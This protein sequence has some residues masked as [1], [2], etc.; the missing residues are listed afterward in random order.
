MDARAPTPG[1]LP[2]EREGRILRGYGFA[3]RAARRVAGL[4]A[5]ALVVAPL[6]VPAPASG[7]VDPYLCPGGGITKIGYWYRI[8]A[9][10]FPVGPSAVTAYS[11]GKL[12]L[13]NL[14][15]TNGH[16][17][18][19][20]EAG[21]CGWREAYRL[22]DPG[23]ASYHRNNSFIA[24]LEVSPAGDLA[25]AVI[26]RDDALQKP[27]MVMSRDGGRT[28][29]AA[30][31]GALAAT[32]GRF[33][34]LTFVASDPRNAYMLVDVEYEASVLGLAGAKVE[35]VQLVFRS[36]NSGA[37]WQIAG[38][39]S[40]RTRIEIEGSSFEMNG[41]AGEVTALEADP[42]TTTDVWA[43]G[44]AGLFHSSDGG[45][46]YAEAGLG[47][48]GTV[49][50]VHV[51][52][53]AARVL[54]TAADDATYF[55]SGDGGLSFASGSLP[56]VVQSSDHLFGDDLA[57]ATYGRVYT[58]LN[59]PGAP[60][61]FFDVSPIDGRVIQDVSVNG[62][63]G[64]A[65]VGRTTT[66][67]DFLPNP[68][69]VPVPEEPDPTV[70]DDGDVRTYSGPLL[71]PQ[72][73]RVVLDPGE[74]RRIDYVLDQPP[75]PTPLDV[76][77]LI[78]VS[79]SMSGTIDGVRSA[80]NDIVNRLRDTG[81]DVNFGVARYRAYDD[82]PAY[83]RTLDIG[84]PGE[85]LADALD[86]L[87]AQGGGE[88][89]QL[90]ALYQSATG[91]GQNDPR[92]AIPSGGQFHFREG[93]LRVA[94]HA[95]D[96]VFSEGYPHPSYETVIGALRDVGIRQVG[97]AIQDITPAGI[98]QGFVGEP[99]HGLDRVAEGTQAVAPLA[100]A[101][102]DGDG[103]SD[104]AYGEPLVCAIPPERADEAGVMAEAIV[105]VLTSIQRPETV[106]FQ[107]VPRVTDLS[108]AAASKVVR[109]VTPG[110]IPNVDLTKPQRLS[111]QVKVGCPRLR[112]SD[113]FPVQVAAISSGQT[114][115]TAELTVVCRVP[116]L[117]EEE[118]PPP[119]LPFL[120]V[121]AIPPPPPRPPEPVPEPN[122]NPQP[123]PQGNPQPQ[124]GLAQQEQEQPQ[125]ALAH[126]GPA[127]E[128]EAPAASSRGGER[129]QM[130]KYQQGSEQR[131]PP[132]TILTL[133]AMTLT[134]AFG[135]AYLLRERTR[136][137]EARVGRHRPHY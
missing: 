88:E 80:M 22:P 95:T 96:E 26:Q 125:L 92:A 54:A 76:Y 27:H 28:W 128:A 81:I 100:G 137:Q 47:P 52:T 109:E 58:G 23:G 103:T 43:F 44:Q 108:A 119:P 104:I 114:L 18:M 94:I 13:D 39:F 42:S 126:Q 45:S 8:D 120:Q 78:D 48:V 84:P 122:P 77:F 10:S 112:A 98:E 46:T 16:A 136:T 60:P 121:V 5:T 69:S 132:E 57:I 134:M 51:P 50:I 24:A 32:E 15:V 113:T 101:D 72:E 102:C 90:A 29:S 123:N 115:G 133:G 55:R 63:S 36:T 12:N 67:V 107:A 105:N 117:E 31:G 7:Q 20:A 14:Y 9:P 3:V 131:V 135:S 21:G 118:L 127:V 87:Y 41:A 64:G 106:S 4:V 61:T 74:T 75:S 111:F 97:L 86:D 65:I 35:T 89:T 130:S 19:R 30:D 93:T 73:R 70:I 38:G 124:G 56:G 85:A 37:S 33:R 17:V 91:D 66:S 1:V 25:Y 129:Y 116:V 59:P 62:L 49:D 79:G 82:P 40:N 99:K 34:D 83:E 2:N 110:E 6:L 71:T 53:Q 68:A 11:V